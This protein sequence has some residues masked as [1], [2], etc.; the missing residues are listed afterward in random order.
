MDFRKYSKNYEQS[1][2]FEEYNFGMSGETNVIFGTESYIPRSF[3]FNGTVNLFGGSI[4]A[5]EFN[6]RMQGLEK[7]I[8]SIVGLDG[9]LNFGRL[10]EHFRFFF[11]K[12]K[13]FFNIDEGM[14]ES[15]VS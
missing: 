15:L 2:F 8:E 14:R 10:I 9:P 12:I 5:L 3:S 1:L 7:Y 6:V 13:K 11:E 4:N